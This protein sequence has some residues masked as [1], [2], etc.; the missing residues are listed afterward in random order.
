MSWVIIFVAAWPIAFGV[1]LAFAARIEP[2]SGRWVRG[3]LDFRQS[4]SAVGPPYCLQRT[5]IERFFTFAPK[6]PPTVPPEVA[7]L[8]TSFDTTS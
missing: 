4:G 3:R 1:L 7:P 2:R 8:S 5:T 6:I